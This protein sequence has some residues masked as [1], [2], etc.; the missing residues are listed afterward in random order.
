[1]DKNYSYFYIFHQNEQF[2]EL[3]VNENQS[4]PHL[5]HSQKQVTQL[6]S[7]IYLTKTVIARNPHYNIFN[8]LLICNA[9][10][11][12]KIR[13]CFY[14]FFQNYDIN[15]HNIY[16]RYHPLPRK[17]KVSLF[18]PFPCP[19]THSNTTVLR[20]LTNPPCGQTNVKN[21]FTCQ[22]YNIISVQK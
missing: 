17:N 8:A 21:C 10:P 4:K 7:Y 3:P 6:I 15:S 16:F 1:M 12:F 18:V 2:R 20:S 9:P 11:N 22:N 14:F 19:F 5:D 13:C